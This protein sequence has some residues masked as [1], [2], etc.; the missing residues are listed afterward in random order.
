MAQVSDEAPAA[1][2]IMARLQPFIG[3]ASSPPSRAADPVNQPMIRHLCQAIE[4]WNPVYTDPDAAAESI[5]G[6]IVAPPAMLQVWN[7]PGVRRPPIP[8]E[9]DV[10]GQVFAILDKAGFTSIVATNCEQEYPRYLRPGDQLT[11]TAWI[12]AI[13][14]EKKTAL[15]PGHFI[16]ERQEYRTDDGEL[17]GRMLFRMLKFKPQQAAAPPPPADA[18]PR[19]P[20]P[21]INADNR[22][23]WE[24]VDDHKLLIQRCASCGM[25]RHPTRPMCPNCQSLDWDTVQASGRG[26]VHS[27]AVPHHPPMPMFPQPYIVVLVELEEGTRIV[28]NLVEISPEAV[29]IGMPVE[30]VFEAV[31]DELTLPLFRPVAR[32]E[33]GAP[34][35]SRGGAG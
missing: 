13:S 15:G 16:Q 28:S 25:L 4:D 32:R 19:R 30:V 20:R 10:I 7:M 35:L 26:T 5:H 3:R 18:T 27:Y 29:V 31:D 2:D 24:G 33:Q 22:F 11:R 14:E 17:V 9:D 23:F 6:G 8:P 21:A 1:T 12:E 34:E